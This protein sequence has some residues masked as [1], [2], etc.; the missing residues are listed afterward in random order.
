VPPSLI[1]LDKVAYSRYWYVGRCW[2]LPAGASSGLVCGPTSTTGPQ[3]YRV[4]V[5]VTWRGQKCQLQVCSF[6]TS[7]LFA[8]NPT[9]PVFLT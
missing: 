8:S 5:A 6:L 9:D 3:L 2:Q 4:V 7:S 1:T